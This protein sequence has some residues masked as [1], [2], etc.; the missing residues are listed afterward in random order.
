MCAASARN[1][2]SMWGCA[3]RCCIGRPPVESAPM[4]R[5]V[6]AVL[7]TGAASRN[8]R[9]ILALPQIRRLNQVYVRIDNF[10]TIF[11]DGGP[12]LTFLTLPNRFGHGKCLFSMDP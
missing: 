2:L 1:Q 4:L 10:E 3:S 9:S 11:H 6:G 7:P 12:F 5:G 8:F